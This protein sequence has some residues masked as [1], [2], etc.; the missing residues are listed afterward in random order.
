[1]KCIVFINQFPRMCKEKYLFEGTH[2]CI[3]VTTMYI[4]YKRIRFSVYISLTTT[5]VPILLNLLNYKLTKQS[6]NDVS[7]C[8][9][10]LSSMA[11][12]CSHS[13]T[14]LIN[15]TSCFDQTISGILVKSQPR[16]FFIK[17][18]RIFEKITLRAK[19]V[20]WIFTD[21]SGHAECCLI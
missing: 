17:F 19:A 4:Y 10:S 18:V 20:P 2:Y 12:S 13:Y 7:C 3:L 8:S 6:F 1:M 14:Y 9:L 11:F 21:Y 15:V 16:Q 5:I